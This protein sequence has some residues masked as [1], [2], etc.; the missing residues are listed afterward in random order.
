MY[1][2]QL[3][4]LREEK[5]LT[6]E[7]VAKKLE[8][9]RST[10]NNW[11]RNVVMIPLDIADKVSLLYNVKL[12]FVLGVNKK[13]E[14]YS[15]IKAYDYDKLLINLK[16]LKQKSKKYNTYERIGKKLG[17]TKQ[18]SQRYFNNKIK[19][20]IDVLINLAKLYNSDIDE[21]CGKK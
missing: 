14:Y 15:N 13:L 11:E 12:S 8:T 19:I 9:N 5:E 20:P 10:Y 4:K 16:Q 6:Q 18:T 1:L 17:C 3:K 2:N 7:K 21:L